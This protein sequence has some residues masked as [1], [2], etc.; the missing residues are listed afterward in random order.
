MLALDEV[1]HYTNLITKIQ[2]ELAKLGYVCIVANGIVVISCSPFIVCDLGALME[3][4]DHLD[5]PDL[6]RG[7][8]SSVGPSTPMQWVALPAG[9]N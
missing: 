6:A 9:R 1:T 5:A 7:L 2:V 4:S 3:A 8:A